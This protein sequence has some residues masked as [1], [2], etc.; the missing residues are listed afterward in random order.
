M[1][2][3]NNVLR[4]LDDIFKSFV[5]LEDYD[6]FFSGLMRYFEFIGK[7]YPFREIVADVLASPGIYMVNVKAMYENIVLGKKNEQMAF[8][9]P[10]N[11]KE[12]LRFHDLIIGEG[13]KFGFEMKINLVI[14]T[15]P[16][17]QRIY[18]EEDPTKTLSFKGVDTD[19]FKIL[20][21]LSSVQGGKTVDELVEFLHKTKKESGGNIMKSIKKI[22]ERFRD[23]VNVDHD[24]ITRSKIKNK[25]IYFIN[26][27]VFLIMKKK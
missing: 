16:S 22:N 14:D 18:L 12:I 24:I 23:D 3:D 13:K 20:L 10:M 2:Q 9:S 6:R 1:Y 11:K 19:R 25:N 21:K 15:S 27:E 4:E 17:N 26:K 5:D 7:K 8:L